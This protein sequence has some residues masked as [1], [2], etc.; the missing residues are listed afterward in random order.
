MFEVVCEARCKL[1]VNMPNHF[2]FHLLSNVFSTT[3]H[4][5]LS[6]SH[7]LVFGVSHYICI[8]PLDPMRIH[9]F[10]RMHGG[11]KIAFCDVMRN[12]F[13]AIV[14]D[15]RFHVS[16]RQTHVFLLLAL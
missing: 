2:I 4:I 1:L 12:A 9:I 3:L 8:Q 15:V 14:R 6:P 16:Q 10:H 5:K 7:P 11:E 13:I